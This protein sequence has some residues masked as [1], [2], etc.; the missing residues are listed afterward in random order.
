MHNVGGH[1]H[2][3]NPSQDALTPQILVRERG[4][5]AHVDAGAYDVATLPHCLESSDNKRS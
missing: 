5:V 3:R 4:D 1:T 2:I